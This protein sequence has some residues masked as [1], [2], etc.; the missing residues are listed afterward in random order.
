MM[1]G[2]RIY[3]QDDDLLPIFKEPGAYGQDKDGHWHCCTPNGLAGNLSNHTVVEHPDGT[4]TVSPS[5][6]VWNNTERWHGF[7]EN[8]VWREC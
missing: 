8:G 5:I 3:L 7:L 1:E 2:K 4:I 6:L